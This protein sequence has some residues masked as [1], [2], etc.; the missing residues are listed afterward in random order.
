MK[1]NLKSFAY[2]LF[3]SAAL[4]PIISCNSN[5][6]QPYVLPTSATVRSFSLAA[7][8]KL[9]PHLD[10]VFFSIDLY[11]GDIFNADS[12]PYGTR[13]KALVPVILTDGAQSIELSVPRPN[14][15]D[16]L[17][18]YL[19][20]TSDSIDFSNGPVKLRIVSLDG[21]TE[22]NYSIKVNVHTVPTDTLVWSRLEKGN[23]PSLFN[24][25]SEQHTAVS[26]D[27]RFFCLTRYQNDY[28]IATTTDPSSAWNAIKSDIGFNPD[29]NSLTATTDALYLLDKSGLLYASGD[30]GASW[31]AT[32]KVVTDLLGAYSKTL[33]ASKRENSDWYVFEYPTGIYRSVPSSFPVKNSSTALSISFE[34]G[35]SPQLI[36]VG[37][38]TGEDKL[39]AATWGYDGKEWANLT[40]KPMPEALENLTVVPYFE[41][42][43]DTASWRVDRK[44]SVLL[45][46]SGNR[47]DGT[48]NDTIFISRDFGM[49]WSKAPTIMQVPTSVL[50]SR[51]RAQA[52]L[53][54][55]RMSAKKAP[56]YMRDARTILTSWT[57]L[58][59]GKP[60]SRAGEPITEWDV[61]YIYLF[62]GENKDGVTY[63]TIYRGA[64]TSLTFKPLQ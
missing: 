45:A 55:S 64:I 7:N 18:N 12:L 10:S 32:G 13:T 62:G 22:R 15:V 34:M 51:T 2:G 41:V 11:T 47:E 5:E 43:P 23:L 20:N 30:N 40:Q 63:N 31:S 28:S 50:P 59:Y 48:P 6:D 35:I 8:D 49:H 36:L 56:V 60:M 17:Y 39:T 58:G 1:T 29:V 42:L 53:Y 19:E 26:P 4:M 61:P 24:V 14:D 38:R 3:V 16:T 21:K 37:G 27:G 57:N 52:Y 9:L 44:T 46:M 54:T 25:V 33:L